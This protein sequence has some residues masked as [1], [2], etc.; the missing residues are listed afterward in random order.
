MSLFKTLGGWITVV[1]KPP[2]EPLLPVA[3][4]NCLVGRVFN[5][6]KESGVVLG[7]LPGD[8][9]YLVQLYDATG[10]LGVQRLAPFADLQGWYF[11][12]AS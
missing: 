10:E 5:A 4:A 6:G 1:P 12:D 7:V 2:V 3:S 9:W 8:G 11:G